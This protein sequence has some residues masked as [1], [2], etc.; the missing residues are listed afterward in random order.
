MLFKH[1]NLQ[2]PPP[3]PFLIICLLKTRLLKN[4]GLS[5]LDFAD[6]SLTVQINMFL[7]FLDFLQIGCWIQTLAQTGVD[8]PGKNPGALCFSRRLLTS[9]G[10]LILSFLLHLLGRSLFDAP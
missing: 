2:S 1:F 6:R 9:L 8:P 3:V 5:G 4:A 7:C 10:L